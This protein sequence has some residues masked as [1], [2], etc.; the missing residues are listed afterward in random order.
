VALKQVWDI[1]RRMGPPVGAFALGYLVIASIFAGL[2][3]SVW[4]ADSAA[5]K[6]LSHHPTLIDFAYYSV[7]TIST[8]GYGDV[9]PQS[10]AAKILASAEALTGLAWTVVIFAAVLMVVQRHLQ[11]QQGGRDDR[12]Q[13]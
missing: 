3:A 11:S 4:R 2:F 7:M 6:G 12:D 9:A 13:E 10:P 1:A 5:F 8:T